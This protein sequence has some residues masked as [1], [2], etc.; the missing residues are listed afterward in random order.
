MIFL[1][2]EIFLTYP[3]NF[4]SAVVFVYKSPFWQNVL[5]ADGVTWNGNGLRLCDVDT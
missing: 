2:K 4:M 5:E 3:K 1:R